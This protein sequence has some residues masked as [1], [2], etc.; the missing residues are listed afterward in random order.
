[1]WWS[2]EAGKEQFT[3]WREVS[4]VYHEG[5]PGHHLHA[6]VVLTADEL[7]RYQRMMS[8]VDGHSEGWALYAERLMYE[9]GYLSDDGALF[10]MLAE[11]LLR[12]ARVIV[13]IG[14]HLESTIPAGTGF[15]EGQRWTPELGLEFL[16]TRALTEPARARFEIDRYLGWPGQAPAYKLGERGW[17]AARTACRKLTSSHLSARRDSSARS[18]KKRNRPGRP[19]T[20]S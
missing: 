10:G 2:L 12:A 14:M 17:L 3:T 19:M 11:Q 9:L 16:L 18:C 7:N 8:F 13:D 20:A 6:I 5:V 4:V 1:M 15:H